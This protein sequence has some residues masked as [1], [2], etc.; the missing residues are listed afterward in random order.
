MKPILPN[1]RF[2]YIAPFYR[3]AKNVAWDY[4][5]RFSRP[6]EGIKINEAEL[7]IDYP[8]GSRVSLYGADNQDALRGLALDGAICDEMDDWRH[9]AY[10]YVVRPALAD[11]KG[12]AIMIGTVKGRS[13][14]YQFHEDPKYIDWYRCIIRASTSGILDD[15][16]LASLRA[17]L[18]DDAYRQEMECDW[19]AAIP[20]AIFGQELNKAE[21][22]GRIKLGVYDPELKT[23]AAMDLG[24][25]DDTAIV[26]FQ[27][28]K[29]LRIVDAYSQTGGDIK[30]ISDVLKAKSYKYGEWLWLPHDA[31]AKTLSAGG[32]TI[33]QQFQNAGWRTRITPQVSLMDGVQAARLTLRDCLIDVNCQG[34]LDSL[35]QYQREYDTD[36]K[37]FKDHPRHD[38]TS[39]Y[40]DAFRYSCLV[41]REEMKPKVRETPRY[42]TDRTLNEIIAMQRRKRIEGE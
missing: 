15:E 18:T 24:Y 27:V 36:K 5:K 40:A 37:C 35:K 30:Q 21:Q 8:N 6:I 29:E 39:H 33:E 34:L 11:R 2:A 1:S 28:G 17:E 26:W 12:W 13:R 4:L 9:G 14:L 31:R 19:D 16:E 25:T 38:W 7:R 3:Q 10:E 41:W 32:R 42:P 22:E 20:G 23:H